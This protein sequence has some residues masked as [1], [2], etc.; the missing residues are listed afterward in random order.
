MVVYSGF[1]KADGRLGTKLRK[2]LSEV[3]SLSLR[4]IPLPELGK[5]KKHLKVDKN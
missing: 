4:D 1:C 3:A 2:T 5:C